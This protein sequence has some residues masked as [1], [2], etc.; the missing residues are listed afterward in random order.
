M[1]NNWPLCMMID[2]QSLRALRHRNDF[3]HKFDFHCG[4]A[5][6][7]LLQ[8]VFNSGCRHWLW[9]PKEWIGSTQSTAQSTS[10][11]LKN[12]KMTQANYVSSWL[13]LSPNLK[14]ATIRSNRILFVW[15]D[16]NPY[17]VLMWCYSVFE[18]P[19]TIWMHNDGDGIFLSTGYE[20]TI[21][22]GDLT[23]VFYSGTWQPPTY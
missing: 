12:S 5:T 22:R 14:K 16:W 2:V 3:L 17:S 1:T 7:E 4:S 19:S 21:F 6:W 15:D 18:R 13:N 11:G 20:S 10:D 23:T 9:T 8:E